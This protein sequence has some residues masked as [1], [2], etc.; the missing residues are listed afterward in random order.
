MLKNILSTTAFLLIMAGFSPVSAQKGK[1]GSAASAKKEL[2]FLENVSLEVPAAPVDPKKAILG[3]Q[4]D[5][6]APAATRD[7]KAVSAEVGIEQASF[8]QLKYAVLLDT[9][10]EQVQ[11][12]PL[13]RAIDEWFGT[14]YQYGGTSK[15]GVDCSALTQSLFQSV[16]GHTLPRTAR[17]QF[18]ASVKISR[19]ELR[20]GDLVFFNTRGGISHVGIYLQNNKFVHASSSEGVTIS[21][22]F[23]EYWMK[24]FMGVGRPESTPSAT[25]FSQP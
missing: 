4:V 1:Q 19:T 21:D 13:F 15:S 17:E 25:L 9:E 6:P 7:L 10:V 24:R 23:D 12:L 20:E 3:I 14:R 22:L 16:Y 2:T 5:R 8:L 11:N 18:D